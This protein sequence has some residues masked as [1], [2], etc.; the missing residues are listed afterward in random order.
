MA[1]STN[2]KTIM[3]MFFFSDTACTTKEREFVDV[4]ALMDKQD[5]LRSSLHT[6]NA[7]GGTVKPIKSNEGG[8]QCDGRTR[9]SQ[10][11]SC[12]EATFFINNCPDTKMDGNNDGVPCE[13]QWCN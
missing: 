13:K 5:Q 1:V 8:Y 7:Q 4:D 3:D 9:C 10:M 12:E 11:T 6:S 2:V